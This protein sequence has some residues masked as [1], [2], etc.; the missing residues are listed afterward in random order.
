MSTT[1]RDIAIMEAELLH[2]IDQYFAAR[3]GTDTPFARKL[4][5]AGFERGFKAG[6]PEIYP[7]QATEKHDWVW[8]NDT[9]GHDLYEC[10]HC[11][12][13]HLYSIDTDHLPRPP[14]DGCRRANEENK[15][16]TTN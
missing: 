4:F 10:S 3:S 7:V 8:Q 13:L 12:Q 11:G 15:T 1:E 14:R 16:C 6:A 5:E 9:F 2:L